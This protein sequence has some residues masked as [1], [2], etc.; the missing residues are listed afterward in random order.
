MWRIFRFFVLL[1]FALFQAMRAGTCAAGMEILYYAAYREGRL[2]PLV[3]WGLRML[4]TCLAY[5]AS[6]RVRDAM[7]RLAWMNRP[8]RVIP[9]PDNRP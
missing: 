1:P 8:E 6:K 9:F 3:H 7:L 5:A 2:H 4:G